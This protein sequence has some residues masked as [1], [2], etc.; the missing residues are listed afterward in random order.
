M[1]NQHPTDND[2]SSRKVIFRIRNDRGVRSYSQTERPLHLEK[3]TSY[4]NDFVIHPIE[5][6]KVKI[7]E[8]APN[9]RPYGDAAITDYRLNYIKLPHEPIQSMKP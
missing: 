8:Q 2:A 7:T 3:V 1:N 6:K 9:I 5:K 4:N